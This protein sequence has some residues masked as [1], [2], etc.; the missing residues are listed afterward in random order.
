MEAAGEL[1]SCSSEEIDSEV[2]RLA[3]G[4]CDL[5][6]EHPR[7][8]GFVKDKTREQIEEALLEIYARLQEGQ[9]SPAPPV[10][11]RSLVMQEV[12]ANEWPVLQ[13]TF[14]NLPPD[15]QLELLIRLLWQTV[16]IGCDSPSPA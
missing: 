6:A 9:Q 8:S 2:D 1:E 16:L 7:I 12:R 14:A 3:I 5:L 13:G 11:F 10:A 15:E 4:L